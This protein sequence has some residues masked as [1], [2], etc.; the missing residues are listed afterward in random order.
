MN[1]KKRVDRRA[2]VKTIRK[3]YRKLALEF[4]PDKNSNGVVEMQKINFAYQVMMN[5]GFGLNLLAEDICYR[6]FV[7][8]GV[9][10]VSYSRVE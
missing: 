9:L 5:K 8:L 6:T 4:H 1:I 2:D 10:G 7:G 3:S